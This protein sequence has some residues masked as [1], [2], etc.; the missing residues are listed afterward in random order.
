[1]CSRRGHRLSLLDSHYPDTSRQG[2]VQLN[3]LWRDKNRR[4]LGRLSW[5]RVDDRH[6]T[7]K[8]P[9]LEPNLQTRTTMDSPDSPPPA[10]LIVSKA[11]PPPS[12]IYRTPSSV[13][14]TCCCPRPSTAP[15]TTSWTESSECTSPFG[16]GPWGRWTAPQLAGVWTCSR[17]C[18][19]VGAPGA[20]LMPSSAPLAT[21]NSRCCRAAPILRRPEQTREGAQGCG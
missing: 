19:W 5:R 8:V 20:R 2:S 14:T 10:L 13:S 12:R 1:M 9:I 17:S 21:I 18:A 15:C 16:R 7:R 11:I 4:Y 3:R 6:Q